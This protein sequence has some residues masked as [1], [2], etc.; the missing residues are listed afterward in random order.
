MTIEDHSHDLLAPR[1]LESRADYAIASLR[2]TLPLPDGG[3]VWS[4]R[5]RSVPPELSITGQHASSALLRLSG[6]IL[7]RDDLQ[8]E[9][10][11]KSAY[12]EMSVADVPIAVNLLFDDP[13]LRDQVRDTIQDMQWVAEVVERAV[14]AQ[15]GREPASSPGPRFGA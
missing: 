9:A 14:A 6:M 12:R 5:D 13:G 4:P 2:K 10:S 3:V 8:G 11:A 15:R 7:K 1:A